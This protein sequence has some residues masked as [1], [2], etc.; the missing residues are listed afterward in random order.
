MLCEGEGKRFV[1]PPP[2]AIDSVLLVAA[3]AVVAAAAVFGLAT[4]PADV[5]KRTS[6]S[7]HERPILSGAE[8]WDGSSRL[9]FQ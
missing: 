6:A 8:A 5:R 3:T 9:S 4:A 7:E 2:P 1:Q